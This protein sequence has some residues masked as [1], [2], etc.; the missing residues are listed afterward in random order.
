MRSEISDYL[1]TQR[2]AV[3]GVEMPDGSPH[4]ATVHFAHSED[5]LMFYFE[6][7]SGSRKAEALRNG[8]KVRASL[9]VGFDESKPKTLQLDGEARLITEVEKKMFNDVYLGKFPEKTE[10]SSG[11][12]IVFFIFKPT[13]WRFTDWHTPQGKLIIT[14]TD[15]DPIS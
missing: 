10:K 1:K 7:H 13:W 4:M 15:H 6:T 11:S 8:A 12:D 3:L 2:I 5:P 14:S 9:V